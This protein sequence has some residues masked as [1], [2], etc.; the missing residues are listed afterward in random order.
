MLVDQHNA[1]VLALDREALKRL[2]NGGRVRLGVDDQKVF[3][4]VGRRRDML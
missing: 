1:N 4:R 2:I 3:L